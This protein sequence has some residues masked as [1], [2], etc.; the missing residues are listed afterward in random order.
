MADF[1]LLYDFHFIAMMLT[2]ST[3]KGMLNFRCLLH[4]NKWHHNLTMEINGEGAR[5]PPNFLAKTCEKG[6]HLSK[7]FC[8]SKH[9]NVKQ[10]Y[11]IGPSC[12]LPAWKFTWYVCFHLPSQISLLRQQFFPTHLTLFQVE[13]SLLS[14]AMV[15][16][17]VVQRSKS[18]AQSVRLKFKQ[19]LRSSAPYRPIFQVST[20]LSWR[21]PTRAL[22][23]CT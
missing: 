2:E 18:G 11:E 6:L 1:V 21:L 22:L 5:W 23:L 16:E 4:E 9:E 12:F 20:T 3:R 14:L 15:L 13:T 8:Y 17:S 7:C 19:T 10:C